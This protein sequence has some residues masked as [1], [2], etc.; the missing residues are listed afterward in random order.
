MTDDIRKK[1][2][3]LR[4]KTASAGATEAEAL[5][6]AAKAAE[7]MRAH[8]LSEAD[9]EFAEAAAPMKTRGKSARDPLWG[10][11]ARCTNTAA[12][13]H[14]DWTPQMVFIGREPGPEIACYL[15]DVL[16]R[17]VDREVERFKAT[18][19]YRRRRTVA[20]RRAAVQDFTTGLVIRLRERLRELFSDTMS[21]AA[22]AR[23]RAVRDQRFRD[24]EPVS[25]PERKV[26][27]GSAV[28][29]GFA[30]G[31]RVHLAH[32]VG[33]AGG[34]PRQIGRG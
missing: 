27:F 18:P 3:S 17:A 7:L 9:V 28:Q 12:I 33:A 26:R 32:G 23:A 6:A 20:T 1:V 19:E 29:A 2:A 31:R 11:V 4:R 8:G 22:A 14:Q 5:A 13:L 30:A 34:A 16:N 25:A 15:V 10:T 24:A 21:D